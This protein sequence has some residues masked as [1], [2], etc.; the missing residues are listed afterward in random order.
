MMHVR[1]RVILAALLASTAARAQTSHWPTRD[2]NYVI[3]NFHFGSGE[4]LPELKLH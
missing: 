2:G 4:S 3:R 1:S